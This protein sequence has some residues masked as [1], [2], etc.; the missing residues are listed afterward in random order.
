MLYSAFTSQAALDAYQE[1]PQHAPVKTFMK[2]AVASR[3][4]MDYTV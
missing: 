2:Q 3:H 4:C 1:H